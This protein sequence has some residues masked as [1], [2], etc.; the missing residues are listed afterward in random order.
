MYKDSFT[1]NIQ[2]VANL[3]GD[4]TNKTF[5]DKEVADGVVG[6]PIDE[7]ELNM[8]DEKLVTL[9]KK[10]EAI[11]AP[12]EGKLK[13]L[14]DLNKAYYLG[15]TD[16]GSNK[17]KS[18]NL[19]F[20]AEETFIP[21]ALS[22]NP[23]PVVWS[24]NTTEGK[25]ASDDI[26]TMLQYQA[27]SQNLRR[28]LGVMVRHWSIYY[29]GVMKHGF[30]KKIND[31]KSEL[32]KPKNFILDPEGYV[33]ENGEFIG[34]FLGER[35]ESTAEDLVTMFPKHKV[36]IT[37]KVDGKMGTEV[38]R[39]EWWTDEYSFTKFGEIILDKYKNPFFNYDKSETEVDDYG[40]ES[41]T[42]TPGLNHFGLP[43][44][45]YTFLSVFSLQEKPHDITNLIEQSIPNQDRITE[46]EIQI[47]RNLAASNNSMTLSGQSFDKETAGEAANAIEA[48]HPIL[49][50]DG[51]MDAVRRVPANAIP[52]SVF[53][54]QMNDK[55]AL[56]SIFGTSG[57]S[58][59]PQ[60]PDTTA[61]G[62]ILNQN[63][64][65]SRIG[66]GVGEAIEGV[67][68]NIFNWWLQMMYVFYD[69]PHYAAMIG[70]GQAVNYVQIINSNIDRHFIVK[71]EPNSMQPKDEITEQNLAIDLANKGWLDPI[72]LFKK[73][74]YPD[75]METAKMVTLYKIDPMAYMQQFFPENAPL[76]NQPNAPDNPLDMNAIPTPSD[77]TLSAPPSNSE[78][79]QVPLNTAAMPQ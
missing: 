65:S 50:P 15:K 25:T 47:S 32:R 20:E 55:D 35:I 3:I 12:Y 21:Q 74:S 39:T 30:D 69:E 66:G 11:Y 22:K 6:Q 5:S 2:G 24:D 73:L 38:V 10:W 52:Q 26:K 53:Q 48:G 61:R 63:Q 71:V 59:S 29:I 45:P 14:Q 76:V 75:P 23:E 40:N 60:T 4:D 41:Q 42:V 16:N 78:L 56:R 64:D 49:I 57:L 58:A 18:A 36:A 27:Y 31:I 79:S 8:S 70:N 28:K 46:R 68:A 37:L 77:Q 33:N 43:K 62:M 67:A 7:L 13:P 54:A 17:V 1:Q 72:N 9:S 51:N 19:I 34:K 44:M